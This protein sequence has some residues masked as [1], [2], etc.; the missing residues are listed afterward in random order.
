MRSGFSA[1][2]ILNY[3]VFI[4]HNYDE[5]ADAR[6]PAVISALSLYKRSGEW[7]IW[8]CRRQIAD[9]ISVWPRLA[10]PATSK[11]DAA[12]E[13]AAARDIRREQGKVS[14]EN[15]TEENIWEPVKCI[16]VALYDAST[17]SRI[18]APLLIHHKGQREEVA[19]GSMKSPSL[20]FQ[21]FDD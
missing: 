5:A 10:N 9:F 14:E 6:N 3:S 12:F 15:N 7:E 20:L 8:V 19:W 2:P 13:M 11:H 16:S 4:N 17:V 21:T 18:L 1:E